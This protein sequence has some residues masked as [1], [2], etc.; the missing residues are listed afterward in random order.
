M[1][2]YFDRRS[3]DLLRIGFPEV[4]PAAGAA[5]LFE[6]ENADVDLWHNRLV[7]SAA[8]L[9]DSWFATTAADRERFRRFRHALPELVN[10]AVRRN[11][12]M[13]LGS[14]YA[15]IARNRNAGR[16]PRAAG[17][18]R[19]NYVI[20]GHQRPHLREHSARSRSNSLEQALMLE[21]ARLL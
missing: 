20:F 21:F 6:A 19:F 3:L 4:P 15:S 16:V 13:K 12:F 9:D 7:E 5:I 17:A 8:L 10:A 1:L 11:G 2:E 14:D 18:R